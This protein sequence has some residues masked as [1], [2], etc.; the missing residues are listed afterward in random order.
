MGTRLGVGWFWRHWHPCV[1]YYVWLILRNYFPG[2]F[3]TSGSSLRNCSRISSSTVI[4]KSNQMWNEAVYS[5]NAIFNSVINDN[6]VDLP[7]FVVSMP[8]EGY[9]EIYTEAVNMEVKVKIYF[10]RGWHSGLHDQVDNKNL[11]I[12][13][14][15]SSYYQQAKIR[16]HLKLFVWPSNRP[17]KTLRIFNALQKL[18][19]A[20]YWPLSI[21][22]PSNYVM[23]EYSTFRLVLV[24]SSNAHYTKCVIGLDINLFAGRLPQCHLE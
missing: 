5:W 16:R 15:T 20:V 24:T 6:S 19:F 3:E 2:R 10:Q 18:C 8:D 23:A 4:Y 1:A 17:A 21:Q 13:N 22:R 9:P 7:W 11:V 14:L 12:V